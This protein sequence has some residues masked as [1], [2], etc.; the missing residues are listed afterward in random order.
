MK[1]AFIVTGSIFHIEFPAMFDG[2]F[3]SGFHI[4]LRFAGGQLEFVKKAFGRSSKLSSSG[5][6]ISMTNP[7]VQN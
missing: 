3:I 7:I 4:L 6:A 2:M 1:F 5:L